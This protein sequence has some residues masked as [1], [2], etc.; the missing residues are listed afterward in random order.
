MT[1]LQARCWEELKRSL[2]EPEARLGTVYDPKICEWCGNSFFRERGTDVRVCQR[3]TANPSKRANV[4]AA[5]PIV[6]E[7]SHGVRILRFPPHPITEAYK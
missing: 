3:C 1:A 5:P 6:R 2:R 4:A 7:R